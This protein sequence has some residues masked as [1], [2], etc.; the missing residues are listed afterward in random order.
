[1]FLGGLGY[2]IGRIEGRS[3]RIFTEI[4]ETLRLLG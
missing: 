4:R 2:L 3:D 1:M